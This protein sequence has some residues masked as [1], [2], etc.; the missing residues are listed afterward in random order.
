MRGR[1]RDIGR[2]FEDAKDEQEKEKEK[3]ND[4]KQSR[5]IKNDDMN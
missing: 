2:G 3:E 4:D 5:I 1:G